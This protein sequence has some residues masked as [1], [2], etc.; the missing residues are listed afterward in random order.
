MDKKEKE[1]KRLKKENKQ[2]KTKVANSGGYIRQPT[3][4]EEY[5]GSRR[6]REWGL[7]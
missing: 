3:A 2:L 7:F 1:I 4:Y 6:M 5:G